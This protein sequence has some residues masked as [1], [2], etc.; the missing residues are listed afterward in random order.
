MS[1]DKQNPA[2]SAC[3]NSHGDKPV[4]LA[5]GHGADISSQRADD[6]DQMALN[7]VRP[8]TIA[9]DVACG[10]GGQAIR[11][12]QRGA[13][14]I[15][16]D[17]IAA[18]PQMLASSNVDRI[19]FL[20]MNIMSLSTLTVYADIIVCQRAIHYLPFHDAVGVVKQ[21]KRLLAP[22]GKLF[23]SASGLFS[24]LGSEYQGTTFSLEKRFAPISLPMQEKHGIY[25]PICLYS[26]DDLKRLLNE[27]GLTVEKLYSSSFGNIKSVSHV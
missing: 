26:E 14:V 11:M 7:H 17:Q 1:T 15:A 27:A 19:V 24:E 5:N 8:T 22:H 6:L 16:I 12:A 10:S 21:M 23:L 3:L 18:S 20:Q 4:F 2:Q 9:L 25:E 13:V